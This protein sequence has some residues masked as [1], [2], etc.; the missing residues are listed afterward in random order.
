[1][2]GVDCD[3]TSLFFGSVVDLVVS[4]E[5]Y[6]ACAERKSLSDSSGK[7]GLTMVNVTNRTNIYVGLGTLKMCLSHWCNPP[8]FKVDTI[9]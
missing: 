4:K 9:I 1:M 5:F 8:K 2:S 6:I 3:T 7:G